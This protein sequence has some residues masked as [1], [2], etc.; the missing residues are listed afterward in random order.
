[1][2]L[3]VPKPTLLLRETAPFYDRLAEVYDLPY[4][5]EILTRIESDRSQKA[6][7]IHPNAQGYA[8]LAQAIH[9]LLRKAGAVE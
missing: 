7:L 6:D 1:M 8:D 3:G 2:L 4:D 9:G 5:G